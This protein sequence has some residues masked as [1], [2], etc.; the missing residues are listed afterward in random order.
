M[1]RADAPNLILGTSAGLAASDAEAFVRSLRRTAFA[2]EVVLFV[3]GTDEHTTAFLRDQ[4]I[5]TRPFRRVGATVLGRPLHPYIRPLLRI[6]PAY[7]RLLRALATI[8]RDGFRRRAALAARISVPH[9]AR[10]LRF[11]QYLVTA[12]TSYGNVMLTDVRDVVFQSDPFERDLGPGV[13]CFLED[14]RQTLGSQRQN[15][16][17]LVQAYGERVAAELADCPIS[18]SGVTIGNYDAVL[19][20]LRVLTDGLLGLPRQFEGIDQAVHNYVLQRGL[21]PNAQL[22]AN[23]EGPV[24]TLGIVPRDEVGTSVSAAIVHQYDR[25]PALAAALR[26]NLG[27]GVGEPADL[28]E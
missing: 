19:E 20:Y 24:L 25:H 16:D 17:W 26:R 18:C 1:D 7:P 23:G 22:I 8:S 3:A 2:G 9:V 21:V 14:E 13:H 12:P 6:Q 28:L 11:Y 5:E 10:F 4:G 27:S 15:R